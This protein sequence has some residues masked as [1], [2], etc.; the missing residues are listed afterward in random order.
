MKLEINIDYIIDFSV[1]G[2][3]STAYIQYDE[4]HG[5]VYLL[6]DGFIDEQENEGEVIDTARELLEWYVN[7]N[8]KIEKIL[9]H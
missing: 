5:K 4:I 6:Y 7:R 9:K 1:N 8:I 2:H 3:L